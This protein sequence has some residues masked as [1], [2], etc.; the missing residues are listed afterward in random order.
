MELIN[1]VL[2]I[3]IWIDNYDMETPTQIP[4]KIGHDYVQTMAI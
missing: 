1:L 2:C 3:H 4:K